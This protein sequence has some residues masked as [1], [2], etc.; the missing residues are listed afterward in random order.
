MLTGQQYLEL[1]NDRGQRGLTLKRVYR[2]VRRED[3][4]VAAYNKMYANTG[5]MTPGTDPHDT[6][7]GMS[8]EKISNIIQDL[9]DGTYRWKP[10]RRVNIPKANGKTRPLGIPSWRDKMV[11]EV[12]RSILES[13]YEPQFSNSS[14]GFRP[15]RGCHTALKEVTYTWTG[16]KWF[17]EGDIRGCFDW[18]S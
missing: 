7:D 13:Y 1:V 3:L 9:K 16:T 2:N 8:M 5:A 18:A 15:Q 4:F 17:I 12:V 6:V 14:H 10:A 11:Q